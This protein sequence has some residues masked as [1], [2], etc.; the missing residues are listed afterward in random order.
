MAI[1]TRVNCADQ[2]ERERKR[3]SGWERGTW[4]HLAVAGAT[5]CWK[6]SPD[7]ASQATPALASSAPPFRRVAVAVGA[8]A[9]APPP[10]GRF[11]SG[12]SELSCSFEWVNVHETSPTASVQWRRPWVMMTSSKTSTAGSARATP[13]NP[14]RRRR[15]RPRRR[16][17]TRR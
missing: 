13:R 4:C 15:R 7:S 17:T 9:V 10:A 14:A 6:P 3:P 8:V 16:I 12:E 11:P 2:G 5:E 1:I